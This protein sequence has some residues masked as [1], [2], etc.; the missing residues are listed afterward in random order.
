MNSTYSNHLSACP[1]IFSDIKT[2]R[3]AFCWSN[4]YRII[5]YSNLTRIRFV[6]N[7][8]AQKDDSNRIESNIRDSNR[9]PSA[10]AVL[11]EVSFS[12]MVKRGREQASQVREKAEETLP[13]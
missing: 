13:I 2:P 4:S 10:A 6:S 11:A 9:S 7:R 3:K 1:I 5:E 8:I 12:S